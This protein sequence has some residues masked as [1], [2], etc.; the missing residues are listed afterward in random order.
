[1]K[2][3]LLQ[4]MELETFSSP[5]QH[6]PD[7]ED[8]KAGEILEIDVCNDEKS[9]IQFGDGGISFVTPEFWESVEVLELS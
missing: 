2:I 8:F 1:M 4:D 7:I 5:Q 6:K 9:E 3:K